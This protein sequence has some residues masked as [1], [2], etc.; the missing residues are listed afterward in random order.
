MGNIPGTT[1]RYIYIPMGIIQYTGIYTG[2][3][4]TFY[5]FYTNTYT[6]VKPGIRK[7]SQEK[8]GAIAKAT[9]LPLLGIYVDGYGVYGP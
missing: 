4:L 8:F 5:P 7:N 9:P 1:Y 6:R 3:Y 2:W